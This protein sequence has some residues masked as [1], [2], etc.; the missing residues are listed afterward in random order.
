MQWIKVMDYMNS[1]DQSHLLDQ[2]IEFNNDLDRKRNQNILVAYPE[3]K[4]IWK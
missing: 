2:Y 3:L 1:L 4:K